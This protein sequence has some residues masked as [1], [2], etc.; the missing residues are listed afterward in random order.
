MLIFFRRFPDV[1]FVTFSLIS[2]EYN[3]MRNIIELTY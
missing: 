1:L 3:S 2:D